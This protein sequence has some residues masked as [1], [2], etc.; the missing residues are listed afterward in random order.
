[1]QFKTHILFGLL[2]G[3]LSLPILNPAN[4]VLFVILV[5]IGSTLPDIDHPKS[6]VGKWFKPIGWLFEHRGF[7]HSIFPILL[8]L[9]L[10]KVY[11]LVFLPIAIG[12]I[13]H[14]MIDMATKQGVLFIHPFLKVKISGFVKT[15][16][17]VESLIFISLIILN[18]VIL[19][20]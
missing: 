3:L 4:S 13:S 19:I 17:I 16:G 11:S 1:M 5:L 2:L 20:K 7:F 18:T 15:G 12:Y 14:I 9:L 8:L 6:K 10:T